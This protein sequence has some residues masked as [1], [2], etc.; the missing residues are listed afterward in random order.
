MRIGTMLRDVIDSFFRAPAT[1]KYPFERTATPTRLRGKLIWNPE[2]CSGCGAC[3][4][5]EFAGICPITRCSKRLLDGPCGGSRDGECEVREGLDCAWQ[6]IYD[7]AREI[8]V[9]GKLEEIAPPH[10]WSSGLDGGTRK[11]VREDQCI[12]GL[13]PKA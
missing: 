1:E 3:R 11:V 6:L 4:L 8:G 7:R 12:A 5:G 2:K 10:N 13:G 9:L